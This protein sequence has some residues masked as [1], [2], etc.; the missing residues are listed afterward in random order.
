MT[1]KAPATGTIV[2]VDW[3]GFIAVTGGLVGLAGGTAA[4][5]AFFKL[6][7]MQRTLARVARLKRD[8]GH[9]DRV[10]VVA[11][12]TKHGYVDFKLAAYALCQQLGLG[13]PIWFE[14]TRRSPG[15]RQA[16]EA[17]ALDG[18]S[19]VIAAGGDG[20]VR[21]V[22]QGLV[23]SLVPL[24][25]VPLGT[26]N[27]LAR[28]LG[29]PLVSVRDALEVAMTGR[30]RQIDVGRLTAFDAAGAMVLDS[31]AFLVISGLGFDAALVSSADTALKRRLGWPAYFISGFNHLADKPIKVAVTLDATDRDPVKRLV[32]VRSVMFGN[33]GLL[34]AGLNLAP[35]ADLTDGL[36]DL[37]TAETRHGLIGWAAVAA[38]VFLHSF[39]IRWSPAWAS[40]R[41][42]YRQ[43]DALQVECA[44]D[45]LVQIDG[46]L[47]GRA[48]TLKAWV[49]HLALSVR[50]AA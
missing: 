29:L 26:A 19:T 9:L 21:A 6:R 50:V 40:G 34:P 49:E 30:R 22:A 28:N 23:G 1:R 39:R 38:Q 10:A 12:P 32:D 4:A 14:T 18:V 17:A 25:I 16:R 35:D 46:E 15:T 20:T 24:G 43:S 44:T 2:K 3:P 36:L 45:Q 27:L 48:A 13:E 31:E 33:C 37:V 11:N 7:R 8:S 42:V 41:L 5:A 47:V